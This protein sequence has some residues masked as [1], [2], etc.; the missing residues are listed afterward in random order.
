MFTAK[1]Y[2]HYFHWNTGISIATGSGESGYPG[3]M[4][5]FFSG[6]CRS[7]GQAQKSG[8]IILSNIT[9]T[10]NTS[11]CSIRE[12]QSNSVIYSSKVFSQVMN[13]RLC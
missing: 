1:I 6:S 12:N 7:P 2:I 11:D 9:I 5:H 3:Q 10:N 13:L 8:F 4:G